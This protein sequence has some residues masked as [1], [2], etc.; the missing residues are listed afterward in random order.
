MN[1]IYRTIWSERTG[2]FVAVAETTTAKGK[3]TGSVSQSV[4]FVFVSLLTLYQVNAMAGA[5]AGIASTPVK[6]AVSMSSLPSIAPTALPD[7]A[8]IVAGNITLSRS[9]TPNSAQLNINQ[10]SDNAIINWRSFNVGSAATVNFN[11]SSSKAVTLN[12]IQ[13][14][15]VSQ[16]FGKINAPGQVFI[17]NANGILFGRT[18]QINVGGLVATTH[19]LSDTDFLAGQNFFQRSG[20][21][22]A[23][24]NEGNITTAIAG[25]AALLAP[26]VRNDGI[27]LAKQ[28]TVALASGEAITL[29]FEGHHF[30]GLT[31]TPSTIQS[32]VN[33]SRA[34]L[35][36]GGLIILSAQ[37]INQLI[38][39][40]IHNSG[41]LSATGAHLV[42]GRIVLQA[43]AKIDFS[44]DSNVDVSNVS[45]QGGSI[46]IEAQQINASDTST[47]DASGASGG[48]VSFQ[49]NVHS[50]NLTEST[51]STLP[52]ITLG[53]KTSI[54]ASADQA[55]NAGGQVTVVA[56]NGDIHVHG[57]IEANDAGTVAHNGEIVI[58]RDVATGVLAAT[59]DVS[60]A[61]LSA[62]GG[63]V[64]TSGAFLKSDSAVVRGKTWLLDP[65]NV[66][67]LATSSSTPYIAGDSVVAANQIASALGNGTSVTISTGAV[68]T[69]NASVSTSP[70]AG[71]VTMTG[72]GSQSSGN[73]LVASPISVTAAS[74]VSWAASAAP[75]LT[76]TANNGISIYAPISASG[77]FANGTTYANNPTSINVSMNASGANADMY[78]GITL[79]NTGTPITSLWGTPIS[80]ITQ[81]GSISTN[82]GIVNL[83]GLGG[84]GSGTFG[85]QLIGVSGTPLITSDQIT[86][87]GTSL[88][89]GVVLNGG[90]TTT[91]LN[92]RNLTSTVTG[93]IPATSMN[94]GPSCAGLSI[95]ANSTVSA[96]IGTKLALIGNSN[97]IGV[98][99]DIFGTTGLSLSAGS[100]LTTIGDVSLSGFSGTY[101]AI[102]L[103][104]AVNESAN[105][106]LAING[107]QM[108]NVSAY[109]DIYGVYIGGGLIAGTNSTLNIVGNTSTG[110]GGNG[111]VI[112]SAL[113]GASGALSITGS[114][115][116][117]AGITTVSPISGWGNTS[118]IGTSYSPTS[119]SISIGANI[120]V[121]TNNLFIH[122][123]GA[124]F[125]QISQTAGTLVG[126]N[127]SIDNSG[128]VINSLTGAI[129]PGSAI[130]S[131]SFTSGIALT[132]SGVIASGNIHIFGQTAAG[133]S[134]TGNA[135]QI[136]SA[137]ASTLLSG[138]SININGNIGSGNGNNGVL[139]N[140]AIIGTAPAST[141]FSPGVTGLYS[142]V[143][144]L[145]FFTL[146][147]NG[148]II[149][150]ANGTNASTATA[151]V[152]RTDIVNW[153]TN[154]YVYAVNRLE[155]NGTYTVYMV[156]VAY[157]STAS[158]SA[159]AVSAAPIAARILSGQVSP[160]TNANVL[161]S[162]WAAAASATN[163]GTAVVGPSGLGILSYTT[164]AAIFGAAG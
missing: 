81:A 124:Y 71:Q 66:E 115:S 7:G 98:G 150:N 49:A 55:G 136:G 83:T 120:N 112:A 133:T 65:N 28:G 48:S 53:E 14:A 163:N 126:G 84:S 116:G 131:A 142:G 75:T 25:Y 130:G 88:V 162:Y 119:P 8:N 143:N 37:A 60:G 85:V 46:R 23:V 15:D 99:H 132:G 20:A 157:N 4:A 30:I 154:N 27:I 11:Q 92:S 94:C 41:T 43:S 50:T 74:G 139:T 111:V 47:F 73:I 107:T 58:G 160:A 141:A 64:E 129:T 21:T 22:G 5:I 137:S 147:N 118:L 117:H 138:A 121:G 106:S 122:S 145:S 156:E 44:G 68:G 76:L 6:A 77:T 164:N 127:I 140:G 79:N 135:V 38:S 104:G 161:T 36:P 72:T 42:N 39:G 155:T 91:N 2:T 78:G 32:L 148:T 144:P 40:E 96:V 62:A 31:V 125:G 146:A 54:N 9:N 158:G 82:G 93:V 103:L 57:R 86:I 80:A 134:G 113:T 89:N 67:I 123:N 3:R 24:V 29:Q 33:N 101:R 114:S 90:L 159:F 87:S 69:T 52:S 34:V 102:N 128:G 56:D 109:G 61:N 13:S 100:T 97:L 26:E 35:A 19:Q 16:I 108:S 149:K 151:N 10:S 59:S 63:L 105:S 1:C 17:I 110:N 152:A 45:G 12:R 18:S 70:T 153:T 95:G 51:Q